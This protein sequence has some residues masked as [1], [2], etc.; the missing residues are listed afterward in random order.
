MLSKLDRIYPSNQQVVRPQEQWLSLP[1]HPL[2]TGG[3]PQLRA[4]L[5]LR[6]LHDRDGTANIKPKPRTHQFEPVASD[7]L[8][9]IA[10]VKALS[11][12]GDSDIIIPKWRGLRIL[13]RVLQRPALTIKRRG[14]WV[15]IYGPKPPLVGTLLQTPYMSIALEK[16][17]I[18]FYPRLR[19]PLLRLFQRPSSSLIFKHG[20]ILAYDTPEHLIRGYLGEIPTMILD[21]VPGPGE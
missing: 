10:L 20:Q 3:K 1:E 8:K 16:D 19:G 13:G 18:D 2:I 4:E 21:G 7:V 12:P 14:K 15:H 6:S 17:R 5:A 9:S 11:S